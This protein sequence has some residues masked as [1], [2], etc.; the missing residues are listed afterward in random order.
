MKRFSESKRE[1][2]KKNEIKRE[3]IRE[4]DEMYK[5]MEVKGIK[6]YERKS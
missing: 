4:V 3:L 1:R 6:G 5:W 2:E